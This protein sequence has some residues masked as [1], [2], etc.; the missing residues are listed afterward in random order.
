M[1]WLPTKTLEIGLGR[2][3][4]GYIGGRLPVISRVYN[5]YNPGDPFVRP[6]LPFLGV[7]THYIP[8]VGFVRA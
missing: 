2:C 7:I 8:I 5:S 3:P 6:F 1:Q 4:S